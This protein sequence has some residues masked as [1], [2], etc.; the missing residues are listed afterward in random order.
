[1]MTVFSHVINSPPH[2]HTHYEMVRPDIGLP[3]Q[4]KL[5]LIVREV[6]GEA[7]C[8]GFTAQVAILALIIMANFYSRVDKSN[9]FQ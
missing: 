4:R 7:T 6:Q 9:N 1:M 3:I 8:G 2:T 5:R